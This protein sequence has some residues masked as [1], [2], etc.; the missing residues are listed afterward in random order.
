MQTHHDVAL[1]CIIFHNYVSHLSLC[2]FLPSIVPA[3]MPTILLNI[4]N[5]ALVG[6][7]AMT[8]MERT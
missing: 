4:L 7:K 8:E 1:N 6:V 5:V 2:A 3:A